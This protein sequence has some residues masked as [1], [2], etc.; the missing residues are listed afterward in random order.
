MNDED[1]FS[2]SMGRRNYN[3]TRKNAIDKLSLTP[4][5]NDDRTVSRILDLISSILLIYYLDTNFWQ[6][7]VIIG[8]VRR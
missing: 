6:G 1:D 2:I 5:C 7:A 8:G 3:M 4:F